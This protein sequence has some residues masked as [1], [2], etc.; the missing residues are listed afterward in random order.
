MKGL[1]LLLYFLTQDE[2]L[3]DIKSNYAY[4]SA[5]S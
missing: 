4:N 3:I 1:R 5:Q 2:S